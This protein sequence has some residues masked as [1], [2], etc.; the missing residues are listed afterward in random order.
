MQLWGTTQA[1]RDI[2]VLIEPTAANAKRV[3]R[4]LGALGM[5][6]ARDLDPEEII[7]HPVTIMATYRAWMFSPGRGT[8]V[9]R[10][11]PP[12]SPCSR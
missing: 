1:T 2:D 9:M 10:T 8:F 6:L 4:A 3:L 5:G 7:R 11:P 12:P